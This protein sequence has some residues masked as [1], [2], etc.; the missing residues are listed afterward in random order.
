[1]NEFF[2]F[3]AFWIGSV[4]AALVVRIYLLWRRYKGFKGLRGLAIACA[5][6]YV[7]TLAGVVTLC[8]AG[9]WWVLLLAFFIYPDWWFWLV[10]PQKKESRT[11]TT[12]EKCDLCG[13]NLYA[14]G[15]PHTTGRH[16]VCGEC[17]KT[18]DEAKKQG[19]NS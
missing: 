14:K 13:N 17:Y 16:S 15:R 5:G 9:Y 12:E 4:V 1:M 18:I 6:L 3:T 7:L 2:L 19:S 8:A 11:C 10:I